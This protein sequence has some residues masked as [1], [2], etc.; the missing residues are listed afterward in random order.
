MDNVNKSLRPVARPRSKTGEETKYGRPMWKD[1]ATGDLFSE[2]TVT[3][4]YGDGFV[5]MP[6]VLEDGSELTEEQIF[7][8]VRRNG[9]VDFMTGENLPIFESIEEADTYA[10]KRSETM[11][12]DED[13]T[14]RM[15]DSM[16]DMG[17]EDD[18]TS[19][20]DVGK[21]IL[22]LGTRGAQLAGKK[23]GM[24]INPTKDNPY[25]FAEGGQAMSLE[26]QMSLF[27]EGGIAD[28]GMSVD[29]V[30]GNEIPP[31]SLA[32]EVRDDI[33][34]QLSEGEYVVP[35]DVL[36][37]YGVRFFEDLRA[38]A[39]QGL[40]QMDADGRIGGEPVPA[41]GPQMEEGDL[42]PEEMAVLQEMGMNVGGF[43]PQQPPPEA[44]GNTTMQ[45]D[46]A[47]GYAEGGLE[48]DTSRA[49]ITTPGFTEESLRKDYGLGFSIF[50]PSSSTS[51]ESTMET[52]YS[53]D[54][55]VRSLRLP[56]EQEEYDRLTSEGWTTAQTRV[57]TKTSVGA[58]AGEPYRQEVR[59]DREGRGPDGGP[60]G[61]EGNTPSG[62]GQGLGLNEN[63]ADAI[64][65]GVVGLGKAALGVMTGATPFG[66]GL[67]SKTT[68]LDEQLE[69]NIS[70]FLQ[71]PNNTNVS[72]EDII[73][74]TIAQSEGVD[75]SSVSTPS[76]PSSANRGGTK[77]S[78]TSS[79][80]QTGGTP[81]MSGA[82][83][84]GRA[85]D[86]NRGGGNEGGGGGNAT[87]VDGPASGASVGGNAPGVSAGP[88]GASAG[89][90]S[91][92]AAGSGHEGNA[93]P[94]A[95]GSMLKKG[96]LVQRPTKKKKNKK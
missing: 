61:P 31:G 52:L 16:S 96:G 57:T 13:P 42:T 37:Y 72:V 25:G 15:D 74:D 77:G 48:T 4:P 11:F 73:N 55:Q 69:E 51:T 49:G 5:V 95:G 22:K 19:M 10:Q 84:S 3:V 50:G 64:S 91:S 53:P 6:S 33:P 24:D 43:V 1:E 40:S 35:A 41:G 87:G 82:T 26:K 78:A 2:K 86:G 93:D 59:S 27:E 34:A 68:D 56:D 58:V 66:I 80:S 54:G 45:M 89:A 63:V 39:K 17:S 60:N 20:M 88:S 18:G 8:Y 85:G 44:V 12:T 71:G 7:D 28:D 83:Q 79:P 14:P 67:L 75:P 94:D 92:A 47:A 23:M 30:S 29:P 32:S 81:G 36:R 70:N 65:K 62:N 90:A 21:S 76:S 46:A 38:E 9:P